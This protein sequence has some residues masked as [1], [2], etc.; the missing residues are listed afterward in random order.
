MTRDATTDH[1]I[2]AI[3]ARL[4]HAG[5]Q[6]NVTRHKTSS[7]YLHLDNDIL[8]EIRV[9][10][11]GIGKKSRHRVGYDIRTDRDRRLYFWP[12]NRCF[13]YGRQNA[14]SVT[15]KVIHDRDREIA[16]LGVKGY[17][18]LVRTA[19]I[20]RQLPSKEAAFENKLSQFFDQAVPNRPAHI[21]RR[22]GH[23]SRQPEAR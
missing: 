19:K 13:Q 7:L 21:S 6:V 5:I 16:A 11:H 18:Q 23:C 8:K 15:E 3:I 22:H 17:Q 14:L 10:D 20:H 4:R 12:E 2:Q 9:S 1:L